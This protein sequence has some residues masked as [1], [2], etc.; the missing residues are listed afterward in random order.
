MRV[1]G[2]PRF[3]FITPC[4]CIFMTN[5]H[6]QVFVPYLRKTVTKSKKRIGFTGQVIRVCVWICG[7]VGVYMVFDHR[8]SN[9]LNN[10]SVILYQSKTIS[11][12][13]MS[14]AISAALEFNAIL[15][16]LFFPAKTCLSLVCTDFLL[17][18]DMSTVL[19][20]KIES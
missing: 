1:I 16:F 10:R 7:C 6:G 19:S 8:Q 5:F 18:P 20:L 2:T 9:R 17:N 12:H 11:T 15:L 4:E 3:Y 14:S 13:S